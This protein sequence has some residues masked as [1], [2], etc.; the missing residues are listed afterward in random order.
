VYW[1]KDFKEELFEGQKRSG[2]S[3]ITFSLMKITLRIFE[4]APLDNG[5][6]PDEIFRRSNKKIIVLPMRKGN[7][8]GFSFF[9][10]NHD[11][12]GQEKS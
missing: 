10:N 8:E 6:F 4:V 11:A 2:Y 12:I 3:K 9:K 5:K 7:L 1:R